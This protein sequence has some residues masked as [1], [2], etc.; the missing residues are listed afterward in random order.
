MSEETDGG[1]PPLPLAPREAIAGMAVHAPSK[2]N[3]KLA[4]LLAA[5]NASDKLRRAG[6]PSR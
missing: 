1:P 4:G 3:R 5:A 2:R 6:T